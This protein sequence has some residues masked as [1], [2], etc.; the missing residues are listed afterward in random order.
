VARLLA[1]RTWLPRPAADGPSMRR[2]DQ[3]AAA[4]FLRPTAAIHRL[5]YIAR[6]MI[7][8]AELLRQELV[9]R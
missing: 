9:A 7:A 1:R 3:P 6:Y 8:R 2:A 4:L 5:A